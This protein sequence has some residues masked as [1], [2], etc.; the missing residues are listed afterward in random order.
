MNL[1]RYGIMEAR[2]TPLPSERDRNY[3]LSN[4]E[5]DWVVKVSQAGEERG[6]LE[7]QNEIL[8]LLAAH[9]QRFRFPRVR[10]ALDGAEITSIADQSGVEHFVRVVDWLPGEPLATVR[11][12]T[13][14][15]LRSIGTLLGALDRILIDYSHPAAERDFYWDLRQG[16]RTI[17]RNLGALRDPVRRERVSS[18]LHLITLPESITSR[19]RVSVIHNDGNDNNLIAR[20]GTPEQPAPP[21]LVGLLDFGDVVRTW[22]VAEL[23][24]ACAYAML[25]KS[26]PLAAADAVAAGYHDEFP[27]T[28]VE[29]EALYPLICIRLCM[30]VTLAAAQRSARPDN[31]YLSISEQPAW[32]LLEQLSAIHP[33]FANYRLRAACGFEP[34]PSAARVRAWLQEQAGFPPIF[35]EHDFMTARVFDFSVSSLACGAVAGSSDAQVWPDAVFGERRRSGVSAAIGRYDEPRPWYTAPVFRGESAGAPDWRTIH[36]GVDLFAEPGTVVCTPLDGVVHSFRDNA[37]HLDY[38]PTIILQH[39]V[40]PI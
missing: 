21:E 35:P 26:D 15:L 11:P 22:T 17:E 24:I 6:L 19:L 8:A 37:G 18:F 29:I 38:G 3:R 12:H 25:G 33:S 9:E 36:I 16:L 30:S 1:D 5:G 10:A 4:G 32:A 40:R 28:E 34:C 20:A 27:L 2:A 7:C 14:E 31:E 13:P 23:A 39:D